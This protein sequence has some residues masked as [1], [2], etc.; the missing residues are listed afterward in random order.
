MLIAHY[1]A[2]DPDA[3]LAAVTD[4]WDDVFGAVQVQTPDPAMNL[5]LNPMA[6]YQ[7]LVCR[8]WGRTGFYQSSGAFGF[9]DQLQ[10]GMA[11][12][13]D[14]TGTGARP[15]LARGRATVPRRDVQHWWFAATGSGVRT[16]ISDDRRGSPYGARTTSR[17]RR[18]RHAR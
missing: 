17:H 13:S 4:H 9:R 16:R 1:R 8:F 2:A 11:L 12:A 14:R 7:T 15:H 10:D 3:V 18:Q 6:A 5:L